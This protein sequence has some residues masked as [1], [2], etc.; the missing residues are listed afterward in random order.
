MTA[1]SCGSQGRRVS[2]S[3]G[4]INECYGLRKDYHRK[5]SNFREQFEL[6]VARKDVVTGPTSTYIWRLQESERTVDY[7][8]RIHSR[9][10]KGKRQHTESGGIYTEASY[11]RSVFLP[12]KAQVRLRVHGYFT[13]GWS[14]R[15]KDQNHNYKNPRLPEGK[16]VLSAPSRPN[17]V[18]W[19][20]EL[21]KSQ[22]LR[23]QPRANRASRT[24]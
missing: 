7:R 20:T 3:K 9:M 11:T 6:G 21:F 18:I 12:T 14:R 2:G 24:F 8:E 17:S 5:R 16:Q 22:V 19:K 4:I 10:S 1:V 23:L 15:H 13:W